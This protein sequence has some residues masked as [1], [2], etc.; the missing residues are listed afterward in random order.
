[1]TRTNNK[2]KLKDCFFIVFFKVCIES[3]INL[4]LKRCHIT[5]PTSYS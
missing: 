2:D 1:M 5:V 4:S 3:R